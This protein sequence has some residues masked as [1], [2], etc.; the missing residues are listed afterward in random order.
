MKEPVELVAFVL[1]EQR[2]GL[3]LSVVERVVR[4]VEVTS[5]PSAPEIV[6]GAINLGG[7]VVPV[8][9]IRKRFM[10]PEKE[11][12]LDDHLIIAKTATRTV[13]L[14]VDSATALVEVSANDITD[15][16]QILPGMD[17]VDGVAKLE[18][19]MILIH[20]LDKFLSLEEERALDAVMSQDEPD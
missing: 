15:A 5:L 1:D 20:D 14:L 8:V 7:R 18:D 3:R 12:G 17:Y 11:I 13:G 4:A 10:F 16:S 9:N 2:F 6:L 19:G